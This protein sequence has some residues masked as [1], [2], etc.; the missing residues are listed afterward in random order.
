MK[1]NTRQFESDYENQLELQYE[2]LGPIIK[3]ALDR[4]RDCGIL[5]IPLK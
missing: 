2:Y 5:P 3:Q 4:Y 1:I